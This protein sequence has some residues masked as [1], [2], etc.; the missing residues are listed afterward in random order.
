MCTIMGKNN[1]DARMCHPG[2]V[3]MALSN[4]ISGSSG[5]TDM[6][7][8]IKLL[9]AVMQMGIIGFTQTWKV[10]SLNLLVQTAVICANVE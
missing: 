3:K 4:L 9:E 1:K 10:F 2:S 6:Q 7:H 8:I 5:S